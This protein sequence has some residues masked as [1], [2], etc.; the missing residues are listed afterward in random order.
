MLTGQTPAVHFITKQRFRMKSRGHVERLVIVIRIL[1]RYE[2]RCWIGTKRLQEIRKAGAAKASDYIPAFDAYV[3]RILRYL[4]KS[5]N[6]G[7][8][9]VSWLLHGSS[10]RKGPSVE[11]D[12]WIV[13]VVPVYIGNLLNCVSSESAQVDAKWPERNSFAEVQSLK[14]SP[15]LSSGSRSLGMVN[16]PNATTGASFSNSRRVTLLNLRLPI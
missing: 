9:V 3:T 12:F 10:D 8:Y 13:D 14:P 6:L 7:K 16:A 2:A 5:L 11:I 1:Q 15:V 4:G